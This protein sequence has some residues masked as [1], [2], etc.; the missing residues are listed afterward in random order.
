MFE[1]IAISFDDLF[2]ETGFPKMEDRSKDLL[3][4]DACVYCLC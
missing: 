1:K 3:N 2:G 4:F